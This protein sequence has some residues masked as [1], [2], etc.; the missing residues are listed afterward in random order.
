ME[1]VKDQITMPLTGSNKENISYNIKSADLTE[2]RP[3]CLEWRA[4]KNSIPVLEYHVKTRHFKKSEF[5][6]A[7]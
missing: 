6:L 7:K 4:R 2:E 1:N 3:I 5:L